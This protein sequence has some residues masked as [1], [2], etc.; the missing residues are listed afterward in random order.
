MRYVAIEDS[1]LSLKSIER[2][3]TQHDD[4][5]RL[6]AL[7]SDDVPKAELKYEGDS[8]CKFEILRPEQSDF[9]SDLTELRQALQKAEDSNERDNVAKILDEA[10]AIIKIQVFWGFREVEELTDLLDPLYGFFYQ[11]WEGLLQ[12]DDDGWHDPFGIILE[13]PQ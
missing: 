10:R 12:G 13:I 5:Y 1:R 6:I 11:H 4:T 3:L 7:E 2:G 9:E 8:I